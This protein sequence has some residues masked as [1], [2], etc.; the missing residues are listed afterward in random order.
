MPRPGSPRRYPNIV[1]DMAGWHVRSMACGPTTFAIAADNSVITW[2]AASNGELG[3]GPNGKKSSAN[4]DK[5][6]RMDGGGIHQFV[7]FRTR[8]IS[9]HDVQN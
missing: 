8:H 3:Y 1:N 7:M 2:G 4:P 5:V 9:V 6:R